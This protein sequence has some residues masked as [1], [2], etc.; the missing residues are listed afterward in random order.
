[1]ELSPCHE[2]TQPLFMFIS[3][4]PLVF[5]VI[6][7]LLL[8]FLKLHNLLVPL[9]C[10][11][12]TCDRVCKRCPTSSTN[13]ILAKRVYIHE[14]PRRTYRQSISITNVNQTMKGWAE[15]VV[16]RIWHHE[17]RQCTLQLPSQR[18]KGLFPVGIGSISRCFMGEAHQLENAHIAST[19]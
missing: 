12:W 1:M 18:R 15:E 2:V 14:N 9:L 16:A 17:Y 6:C 8:F 5:W 4:I 11:L 13:I 3:F 19:L 10:C 7:N